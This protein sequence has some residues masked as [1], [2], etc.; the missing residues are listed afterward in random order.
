MWFDFLHFFIF[1]KLRRAHGRLVTA[2]DADDDD[3]GGGGRSGGGRM[4]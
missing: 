4:H 3:G 2:D 1:S